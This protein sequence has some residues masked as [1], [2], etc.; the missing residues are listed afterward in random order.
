VRLRDWLSLAQQ[1]LFLFSNK[2]KNKVA[3]FLRIRNQARDYKFLNL[4]LKIKLSCIACWLGPLLGDFYSKN[5]FRLEIS[6]K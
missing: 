6:D 4:N 2:N 1:F 3:G 5:L